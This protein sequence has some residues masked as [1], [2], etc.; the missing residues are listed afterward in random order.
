MGCNKN[1]TLKI[2][3]QDVFAFGAQES[4]N[5]V[6]SNG[7]RVSWKESV[8]VKLIITRSVPTE[9]DS[10]ILSA[11]KI[12]NSVKGRQLVNAYRDDSF[13]NPPGNDGTNAIYWSSSWEDDLRDQQAR[14][15]VRWDI[16]K[17]LDSDIRI[18]AKNFVY[19]KNGEIGTNGKVHLESLVLHEMGHAFGLAHNEDPD[20]VMNAYLKSET[21]R[22]KP[23]AVD[24]SSLSCEY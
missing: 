6:V 1:A 16:S 15:S 20:S 11:V 12:W 14:T 5:F 23:G 8:P 19:Y 4:C 2:G 13:S 7:L 9:Y 18:N 24:K 22:D 3:D 10:E 21:V 17:I